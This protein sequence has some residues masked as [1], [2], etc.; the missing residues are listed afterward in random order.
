MKQLQRLGIGSKRRQA[1]PLTLQEE[2]LLWEKDLLIPQTL[3]DTI[4][5]MNR[6]YFTLKESFLTQAAEKRSMSI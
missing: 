6:M 3:L 4:L 5:F 2:E 1:E